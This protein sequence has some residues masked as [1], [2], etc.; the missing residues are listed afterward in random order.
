MQ[1]KMSSGKKAG[2]FKASV[3]LNQ[4]VS[5]SPQNIGTNSLAYQLQLTLI[6]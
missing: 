5:M 6:K 3:C 4:Y 2:F 1:L